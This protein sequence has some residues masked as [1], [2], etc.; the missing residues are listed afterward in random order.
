MVEV[1]VS[2]MQ[3][4]PAF[5]PDDV[6]DGVSADDFL[7]FRNAAQNSPLLLRKLRTG[8]PSSLGGTGAIL[9]G[10]LIGPDSEPYPFNNDPDTSE[11]EAA[12]CDIFPEDNLDQLA[13]FRIQDFRYVPGRTASP[14]ALNK[15]TNTDAVLQRVLGFHGATIDDHTNDSV[16]WFRPTNSG[17]VGIA[18]EY[19]SRAVE[20][21]AG[22]ILAPIVCLGNLIFGSECDIDEGF[23]LARK[24]NPVEYFESWIPGYG[25]VRGETFTGLWHYLHVDSISNRFNDK[26]GMWYEGAGPTYP[27]AMDLTIMAAADLSGLSLNASASDGT[28][29]YGQYD[30]VARAKPAWQAHSIGHLEFSAVDNL[31][32][33]GWDRFVDSGFKSAEGLG[34]PLHALGDVAEPHHVVATSA[35]G[36]RPY[37]DFVDDHLDEILP[38]GIVAPIGD[39]E[40]RKRILI[41]AYQWWKT[42]TDEGIRALVTAEAEETRERVDDDGDWPY[43]DLLS[44]DYLVD[45]KGASED[46]GRGNVERMRGLVEL[47]SSAILGFL[48]VAADKVV[49]PGAGVGTQCDGEFYQPGLTGCHAGSPE[50]PGQDPG[51]PVCPVTKS[52][53]CNSVCAEEAQPC[54][55]E[56]ECCQSP[57]AL[58]CVDSR[59]VACNTIGQGCDPEASNC[60]GNLVCASTPTGFTC[61]D[62]DPPT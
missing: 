57:T 7:E 27:G 2:I 58:H 35:W 19:A 52:D 47:G 1:A 46:I 14:C 54:Q 37:E 9:G 28:D 55:N 22:A 45:S 33:F 44:V 16:L 8:L 6:P 20:L 4:P 21:L 59:C 30:S 31:A 49:D 32:N 48:V 25:D 60:C 5:A 18:K 13:S 12:D 26:R 15:Q 11:N 43:Q 42:M 62:F 51:R 3:N 29:F 36:H 17:I 24:Y 10:G 61:Q 34:W 50:P 40:Q 53:P 38:L 56:A 23:E 39:E 41:G